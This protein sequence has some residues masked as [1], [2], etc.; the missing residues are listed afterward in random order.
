MLASRYGH[1]NGS[2]PLPLPPH[3]AFTSH[4]TSNG[5]VSLQ[6]SFFR[7]GRSFFVSTFSFPLLIT[8]ARKP[9]P[10]SLREAVFGFPPLHGGRPPVSSSFFSPPP[11][12]WREE[13]GE[14]YV[15]PPNSAGERILSSLFYL[16]RCF[17]SL[18]LQPAELAFIALVSPFLPPLPPF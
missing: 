16:S 14:Y 10:P 4:R 13:E 11:P 1:S 3:V 18:I 7:R 8:E 5:K 6:F 2:F 15:P 9:M 17:L 12:C